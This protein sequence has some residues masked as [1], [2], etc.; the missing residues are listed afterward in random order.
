MEIN[1][2]GIS[3]NAIDTVYPSPWIIQ[4]AVKLGIPMCINSDAHQPAHL[5]F[6]FKES[7]QILKEA[8]ASS[9]MVLTEGHWQS[10]DL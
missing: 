3:R 10:I 5:D 8:G 6:Y 7:R 4:K 9:V 1:T 2:G